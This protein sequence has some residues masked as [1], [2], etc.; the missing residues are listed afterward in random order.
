MLV[1]HFVGTGT[2]DFIE[3]PVPEPGPGQLLIKVKANALCGSERGQ[4]FGGTSVTPGHEAAGVVAAAG[5][6]THTAIGTPGVIFLMDFCGAC[7]S[8]RL[9]VTN[10]CLAKRG[11]MG[12]TQDGGY[13]VYELVHEHIFFP[14]DADLPLTEA[15]LLLDIM[16]TSGHALQRARLVRSDI[17]SL[18]ITGAGP[19]GLGVLAMAKVLLGQD[20]PVLIADVVPYRLDLAQRLGGIPIDLTQ[21]TLAA[22]LR[23]HGLDAVDV[24]IDTSGR[25]TARR[26]G[27]DVLGPRG[28]LV[29]LGHGETLHL[30]VSPDLIAPERAILGSE[31][32]RYDE[33]PTNL[34]FLRTQLPYLQQII[35]HRYALHEIQ[36]AFQT[37][38]A[39]ATGKVV[40]E[41]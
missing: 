13:G 16:G 22:G 20:I 36:L 18:A 31:Y 14:V 10:Q 41:Q 4:F 23:R 30:T 19:I 28:V 12:F 7:R 17:A 38:F 15:T 21:T 37:F 39:G 11:D 1:P 29:C 5:P 32:F 24:A 35:T 25:A 27:L 3:K 2:I 8:C 34:Q 33:L 9:G 40:I 6:G 26:A